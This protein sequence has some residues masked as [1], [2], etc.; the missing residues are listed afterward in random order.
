MER[1]WETATFPGLIAVLENPKWPV[2]K[3]VAAIEDCLAA[4]RCVGPGWWPP[5][6]RDQLL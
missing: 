6:G 3:V 1:S 4:N 5:E 2:A